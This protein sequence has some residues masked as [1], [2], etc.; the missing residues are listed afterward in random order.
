MPLNLK[1]RDLNKTVELNKAFKVDGNGNPLNFHWK[2]EQAQEFVD[3]VVDESNGLLNKFRVVPMSA[4]TKEI[5]KIIDDGKFL[6]PGGSYKRTGGSWDDAYELGTEKIELISKKVEGK[7]YISDDELKDNIEG[8][9]FEKHAKSILAKKIANEM[10]EAAIYSRALSNP[11]S[12]NGILNMFNWLKFQIKENGHL[13]NAND[14]NAFSS[15]EITRKV[16]V[17]AKKTVKTKYRESLEAFLDNDIKTDLDELYNAPNNFN[18]EVV[19]T[20]IS[21]IPLNGVPLMRSDL[22]VIVSS[23]STTASSPATAWQKVINVSSDKTATISAW[24]T[25]VVNT[26]LASEM[27]YTVAS[28]NATTITTEENLMYPLSTGNTVHKATT[29][30][31]DLILTN[32]KNVIIWI[33]LDIETEWERLAPDGWNLWYKM[34]MDILVENPEAC[35]LVENLKSAD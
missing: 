9:W 1:Q 21:G 19:K 4:P 26:G 10:V 22:P 13:L 27:S 11:S 6:K 8:E 33:H 3:F 34:R 17:K 24:D 23:V 31:A 16:F 30:G 32:P 5:A 29:D 14:T 2:E 15:R 7:F 18:A 28:I 20:S 35:V 12:A 25:I